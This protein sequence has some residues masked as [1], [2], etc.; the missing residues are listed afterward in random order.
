MVLKAILNDKEPVEFKP[1][2]LLDILS[3]IGVLIYM[4]VC[5]FQENSTSSSMA[6]LKLTTS[7]QYNESR[8]SSA[9]LIALAHQMTT[10]T[11]QQVM[12]CFI[13]MYGTVACVASSSDVHHNVIQL[14]HIVFPTDTCTHRL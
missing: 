1:V 4:C 8:V 3:L 12:C 11:P 7:Q 6:E 10:W 9:P 5:T 13:T 14:P 2:R